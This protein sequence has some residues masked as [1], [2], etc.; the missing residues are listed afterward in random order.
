V[1]K[2]LVNKNT[3]GSQ[4][5]YSGY[6]QTLFDTGIIK[7]GEFSISATD[8]YV[9]INDE[10]AFLTPIERHTFAVLISR[11]FD[12]N[13]KKVTAKN[14]Y[15]E[16]CDNGNNFIVGGCYD[17]TV[18]KYADDISDYQQIPQ[19]SRKDV[20]KAYY[21]GIFNGDEYGNF[22]PTNLLTR[23]EMSKVISVVIDSD[24]RSRKEYR[25]V[26]EI[27]ADK[28]VKDGWGNT[29]IDRNYSFELLSEMAK[30]A[31]SWDAGSGGVNVGYIPTAAPK[32]YFY[33][34][35]FYTKNQNTYSEKTKAP[36]SQNEAMIVK[37]LNQ[38][39]VMIMLRNSDTAEVEGVLRVE[40]SADGNAV[41]DNLFKPV[42]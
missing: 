24:L 32:G 4:L 3:K 33:D 22:N 42:I 37:N 23:A 9:N 41:F 21:N 19:D 28:F 14:L 27:P 13:T 35:R 15:P 34:V 40:I 36:I 29:V 38:P 2:E 25:N 10:N 6:V 17:N 7:N 30:N 16:I 11:S 39:R 18:D 1:K 20:L 31:I 8:G 12:I 26:V 5:W